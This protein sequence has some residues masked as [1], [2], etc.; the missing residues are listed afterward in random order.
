MTAGRIRRD[1]DVA[2]QTQRRGVHLF[3]GSGVITDWTRVNNQWPLG[4]PR[5]DEDPDKKIGDM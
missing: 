3:Q 2:A 4:C 1:L 5:A